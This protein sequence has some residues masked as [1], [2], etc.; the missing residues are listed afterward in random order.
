LWS[1]AQHPKINLI[2]YGMV[3]LGKKKMMSSRKFLALLSAVMVF[4]SL[5][6]S[7]ANA[8]LAAVPATQ[9]CQILGSTT[10]L[11]SDI[12]NIGG[13]YPGSRIPLDIAK[14]E[15]FEA[16]LSSAAKQAPTKSLATAVARLRN[17]LRAYIDDEAE[18]MPTRNLHD[19]AALTALYTAIGSHEAAI[20]GNSYSAVVA[21]CVPF[22]QLTFTA[23]GIDRQALH[24]ATAYVK[25]H[26]G[27]ADPNS[28]VVDAVKY[29]DSQVPGASAVRRGSRWTVTATH[30]P[31]FADCLIIP[32]TINVAFTVTIRYGSC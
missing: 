7:S 9:Y 5:P 31:G 28:F 8:A 14:Q 29:V 26:G 12:G 32:P 1:L 2:S 6:I 25:A 18:V 21:P 24:L 17:L 19:T 20:E 15:A 4:A 16:V 27:N 10:S 23:T 11:Y 3:N 13:N 22:E 30:H